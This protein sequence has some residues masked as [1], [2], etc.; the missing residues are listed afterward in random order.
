MAENINC[1]FC[2][3]KQDQVQKLIAGPGVAICD[4]C[5]GM[6]NDVL[7]HGETEAEF[8]DFLSAI[9]EDTPEIAEARLRCVHAL[10]D[11]PKEQLPLIATI[12]E[13]MCEMVDKAVEIQMKRLAGAIEEL[14]RTQSRT[15]SQAESGGQD[16]G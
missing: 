13:A 15:D 16:N 11:L 5:I 2:G 12:I 10:S 9:V 8:E 1:S 6:C 3:K 7:S 4:E 14:N